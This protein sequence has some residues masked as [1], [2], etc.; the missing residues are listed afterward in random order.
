MTLP[1]T[2][3]DRRLTI[4]EILEPSG[5]GS[6]RHFVDLCGALAARGHKV[7]AIYSPVR[8]EARFVQELKALPLAGIHAVSMSRAPSSSDIA[9]YREIHRIIA[10]EGPFDIVHGHSSKAGALA[11]IGLP[12]QKPARIYTP[13][14]FRTMDPTLGRI[15]RLIY[16]GIEAVLG[17]FFSDAVIC[18]SD[19]EKIHA[20]RSLHI[21]E[22]LLH[23][24][25]NGVVTPPSGNR[26]GIRQK[27]GVDPDR[28]LFGFVGRLSAQKA[29]E[30]L[31]EAFARITSTDAALAIIGS[32]E[33]E[34]EMRTLVSAKGLQNR[35][36]FAP[37]IPGAEAMQAFDCLVMP[38]RYEAMSYVMLEAAAAGLP[39]ILTTVGG[40]S[41]VLDDGRNGILV[42]N[43]D[44]PAALAAA[45]DRMLDKSAFAAF[46]TVASAR[47]DRYSLD[48]MVEATEAV[49]RMVLR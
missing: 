28:F 32:G 2:T 40:A 33:L 42:E 17:R 6:G 39:M 8:A 35:V 26:D 3:A 30:R 7:V 15:G 19:D 46:R 43:A 44:D 45:M 25:V 47:R 29:P 36:H 31:I 11:R 4:L 22:R 48:R 5:G 9:A 10:D 1:A 16:G 12:G 13:H 21:P 49:Y 27:L 20:E 41:T 38:S 23:T 14:A 34:A 18:V 37:E 24:V